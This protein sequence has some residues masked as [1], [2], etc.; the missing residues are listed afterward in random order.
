VENT[1]KEILRERREVW[2][3]KEV[4]RRLYSK[5]YQIIAKALKQG[6]ILE[7]GGGSGNLHEFF[8]NAIASDIIFAPWLDAVLDALHLPFKSES[9]DNIVLFDVLHHLSDPVGFFKEAERV[10]KEKGRIVLMEPYVSWSSFP[11]YKFLHSEGMKWKVDPFQL[12][13][14]EPGKDPFKGNQAI[15]TLL[16][17]KYR[18][19]FLNQFPRLKIFTEDRTDFFIYPLSGGFHN[20][21]FFPLFLWRVSNYFERLFRPLKRFVAFRFFV[22]LEK[23]A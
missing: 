4:I 7:L 22:V 1:N 19:R 17:E 16:L 20:P 12:E 10:L 21:S 8:P 3:S 2:R 5:W 23:K 15:P 13:A 18:T 6:N 11:V 9:L 14:S